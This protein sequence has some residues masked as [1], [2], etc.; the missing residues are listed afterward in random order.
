VPETEPVPEPFDHRNEAERLLAEAQEAYNRQDW[1]VAYGQAGRALRLYLSCEY[2]DATEA[3]PGEV[4]ALVRI[5][6]KDR[7]DFTDILAQCDEVMF[8]KGE[9]DAVRFTA[10]LGRIRQAITA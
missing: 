6:G 1:H 10:M 8:A 4:L 2:G 5:P 9:A 3:S 7:A